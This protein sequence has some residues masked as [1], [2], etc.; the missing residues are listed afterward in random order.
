MIEAAELDD[1]ARARA[2]DVFSRLARAEA[3]AHGTPAEDVH[4]HELGA[5]DTLLD[6]CAAAEL[7]ADLRIDRVVCSPLPVARGLVT[8]AH[9]VL[10]LPSPATLELL[11]GAP[12]VASPPAVSW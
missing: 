11:R 2:L 5:A 4:F 1:G 3:T 6:V 9:G 12:L 7:L 8:A 10:P